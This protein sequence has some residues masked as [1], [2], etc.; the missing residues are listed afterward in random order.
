MSVGEFCNR[1]VVVAEKSASITEVARL[2]REQHVGDVIIVER[3]AGVRA[4]LGIVTDRDLVIQILAK[5]TPV[6]SCLVGDI[7]SFDLVTANETDGIWETLQR[8]RARGVRRVPVVNA[9]GA[10]VGI[11]T[12]DDLLEL[13]GEELSDLV[14]VIA[15][16]P[17]RERS[18]RR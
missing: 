11:L 12:A 16:Q 10:L 17:A 2:M 13:L 14:K 8:M 3:R 7:M 18:R 1:E 6:E 15:S 4:P 5:S 9:A